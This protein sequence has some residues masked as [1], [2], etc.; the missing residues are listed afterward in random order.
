MSS[1][2]DCSEFEKDAREFFRGC[3]F[4]SAVVN[5]VGD[6]SRQAIPTGLSR[7]LESFPGGALILSSDGRNC[8]VNSKLALELAKPNGP[9]QSSPAPL[10]KRGSN[11]TLNLGSACAQCKQRRFC[12]AGVGRA[13]AEALFDPAGRRAGLKRGK[14]ENGSR[15][16]GL[17]CDFGAYIVHSE[18]G[19]FA[20]VFLGEGESVIEEPE[21]TGSRS[22]SQI[23]QCTWKMVPHLVRDLCI[24]ADLGG[25][26]VRDDGQARYE[27][28][29]ED[30]DLLKAVLDS[31]GEGVVACNRQGELLLVN[32]AAKRIFGSRLKSVSPQDWPEAYGCF[33][34]DRKTL[35]PA[36]R[37]A[38]VRAI[39]GAE[40]EAETLFIQN[41]DVPEGVWINIAGWPLIGTGGEPIGGLILLS[42]INATIEEKEKGR[43]LAN[44][45]EQTA[46]SVLIT[47][48][49]GRIEYV[50]PA[51]EVTTGYTREEAIGRTP[52]ILKS[53]RHGED[54][55]RAVWETL[56][57]GEPFRGELVNRKKSGE[58]YWVQQTITPMK[59]PQGNI[60]DFVA[61]LK[62]ITDMKKQEEHECQMRL[63]R[64]VQ[65]R[66]YRAPG[67]LPGFEIASSALPMD[68][69]GGDYFDF[70]L[71]PDGR[72]AVAMA[73]VSGHGF[74]SALVMAETRAYLRSEVRKGSEPGEVLKQINRSLVTDLHGG[75][76][77]TLILVFM[78]PRDRT[79]S[80]SSAGHVPGYVIQSN[81]R[82]HVLLKSTGPPLGLF[83]TSQ[84]PSV[85]SL[86]MASDDALVLLTDGVTESSKEDGE[87]FGIARTAAWLEG[88]VR[89]PAAEILS[90]LL[91]VANEFGQDS[92]Q[93][94]DIA[95][96]V[97]KFSAES[98]GTPH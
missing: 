29:R 43:R 87:E 31:L 40:V 8:W 73:D 55:Y 89:R 98:V 92:Q 17:S 2:A 74:G 21:T 80:F 79:L 44:A 18:E 81:G 65:Q 49:K 77:V 10:P 37:F 61:V 27:A 14:P 4:D 52:R 72:L 19:E 96:V 82:S 59:D 48:R 57:K 71:M 35:V 23:G 64:E 38:L 75:R 3:D 53:G 32:S 86:K 63:A 25:R 30:V 70:I 78:D 83:P 5:P 93:D 85:R 47:D 11:G 20:L 6:S 34:P 42:D 33:L 67:P 62:D 69:T 36:E 12:A 58:L 46:D 56:L 94:D 26:S 90:G 22:S 1:K 50:N 13:R 95:G 84:F 66:F 60:T 41:P 7:M 28:S 15:R 9:R 16:E 54:F 51:F 24:S 68:A 45:V 88:N 76:Y 39:L 91:E 97:C